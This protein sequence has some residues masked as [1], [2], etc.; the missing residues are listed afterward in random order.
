[1]RFPRVTYNAAVRFVI[2]S[3]VSFTAIQELTILDAVQFC[4]N[5]FNLVG[6]TFFHLPLPLQ[7][8]VY[9]EL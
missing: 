2:L 1:M 6:G 7:V 8:R 5:T 9:V 4:G 3:S